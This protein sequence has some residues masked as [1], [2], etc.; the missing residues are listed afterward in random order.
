M[1]R[2]GAGTEPILDISLKAAAP[3][4]D[5]L[6]VGRLLRIDCVQSLDVR[7]RGFISSKHIDVS[8]LDRDGSGQVSVSVELRL[9]S[10]AIV[11]YRIDLAGLRSVV[12][13]RS[14]CV[15]EGVANSSETVALSGV[16]HV[17]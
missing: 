10:P 9:L 16:D 11:L 6:P 15:N 12:Q 7:H 17:W 13:S 14:N 1:L 8:L 3:D 5:E 4:F 2:D